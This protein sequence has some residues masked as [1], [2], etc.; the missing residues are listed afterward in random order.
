MRGVTLLINSYV[1]DTLPSSSHQEYAEVIY[2]VELTLSAGYY[3][4]SAL[5]HK[6]EVGASTYT[7]CDIALLCIGFTLLTYAIRC[8]GNE[9]Q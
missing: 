3:F 6:N 5:T 4:S 7:S 2:C 8:H 1:S 9:V